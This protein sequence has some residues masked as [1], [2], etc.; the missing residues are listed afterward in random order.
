[1][2]KDMEFRGTQVVVEQD[3]K[4]E[5]EGGVI[6]ASPDFK[7]AGTV[8]A[9]GPKV[10]D[11]KV[12]DK[13]RFYQMAGADFEEDGKVYKLFAEDEIICKYVK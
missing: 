3:V 8:V 13:V 6:L 1:M 9:V 7:P 2:I 10:E 12:G 11:F 4:K 5:S